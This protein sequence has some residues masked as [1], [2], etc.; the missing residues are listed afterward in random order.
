M[1]PNGQQYEILMNEKNDIV[2]SIINSTSTNSESTKERITK[3]LGLG[4][5][6]VIGYQTP[7]EF[8]DEAKR[9]Y[10]TQIIDMRKDASKNDFES[11]IKLS[12]IY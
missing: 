1:H 4:I 6:K 12:Y 9:S 5:M 10:K 2:F 3:A 7:S 11:F 8:I